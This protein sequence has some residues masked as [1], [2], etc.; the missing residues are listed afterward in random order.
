LYQRFILK[1]LESWRN[2]SHRKPL[3][4]RGAR[5]VGKTTAV[6]Q[7]SKS[8]SRFLGFNLEIPSHR[9]IF[10]QGLEVNQLIQALCFF[11]QVALPKMDEPTLLFIDEIQES[12]E[13]VAV[14]RYFFEHQPNLHVIAAGSM[15]ENALDSKRIS[16]PVGR[17]EFAYMH[18]LSFQ[19]F[20]GAIG[21]KSS[22]EILSKLHVPQYAHS[23]LTELF[24]LYT[25]VGGMP[26]VVKRYSE[27]KDLQDL[28]SVYESLAISYVDD[29]RKYA[30][31]QTSIR[32]LEHALTLAPKEAGSRV[33]FSGFGN[34]NYKSREMGGALRTLEK[35]MLIKLIY[36]CTAETLPL[37]PNLSKHPKLQYLDTGLVNYQAGLR[38]QFVE[39]KD[40]QSIFNGRIAEHV[41]GQQLMA[42]QNTT[43]PS[44][45]FWCRES[46]QSNAEIDFI[47]PFQNKVIPIEVKAGPTGTLRSLFEFMDRA[48]HPF[49][50]RFNDAY[51]SRHEVITPKGTKFKLLNLPHY[52][53]G[54]LESWLNWHLSER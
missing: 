49:A 39:Q 10:G 25:L 2:S 34:S 27:T 18:P 41:V 48:D 31:S 45:H 4:L 51:Y 38:G 16:F 26:E 32:V 9:S 12:P 54:Q 14:L 33:V 47:V 36:P 19:E 20:L 53:A 40:L 30:K 11:H 52:L 35:A 24:R 21:E 42:V 22:Q 46:S 23:K 17:V 37:L 43:L 44:L 7:F 28:T 5:Q 13:A 3:V 1:Y 15:L 6:Q 29:A 50:V 8:Y